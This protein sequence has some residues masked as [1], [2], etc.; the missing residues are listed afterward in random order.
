[1]F[2]LRKWTARRPVWA[3][4]TRARASSRSVVIRLPWSARTAS[5]TR[6]RR[7]SST[8]AVPG[9]LA[10]DATGHRCRRFVRMQAEEHAASQEHSPTAAEP[11]A[12]CND[13]TPRGTME[14][15]DGVT[16]VG[17]DAEVVHAIPS[18]SSPNSGAP[19]GDESRV[20]RSARGDRGC[21]GPPVRL[22]ATFAYKGSMIVGRAAVPP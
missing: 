22:Y 21:P 10:S 2:P 13:Q 17:G 11:I 5:P 3:A 7:T 15:R 6:A 16:E 14:E 4:T 18:P 1:M 8:R 20:V 12:E 19:Q 9:S